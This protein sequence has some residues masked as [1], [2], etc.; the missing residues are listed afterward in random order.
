MKEREERELNGDAIPNAEESP[1]KST[2]EA[3]GEQSA[4]KSDTAAEE[5]DDV[6]ASSTPDGGPDGEATT[7]HSQQSKE[8]HPCETAQGALGQ[9]KAKV[10]VCK[11]ESIGKNFSL[12][13][14][15]VHRMCFCFCR[16]VFTNPFTS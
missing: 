1:V 9:V 11:D 13:Y 8:P 16:G 12:I 14:E 6:P 2:D 10:E 3:N 5:Q 15:S 4:V 7:N